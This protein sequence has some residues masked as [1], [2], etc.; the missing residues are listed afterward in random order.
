MTGGREIAE[1]LNLA[2]QN[3]AQPHRLRP[4]EVVG[5]REVDFDLWRRRCKPRGKHSNADSTSMP[6]DG[7]NVTSASIATRRR[8]IDQPLGMTSGTTV[9]SSPNSFRT[10][11][12]L[13]RR[14]GLT[15][16]KATADGDDGAAGPG[17][18]RSMDIVL[19]LR[20]N[21]VRPDR[22]RRHT[23]EARSD[24]RREPR[25][26]RP[27]RSAKRN[28]LSALPP[29][30]RRKTCHETMRK[31]GRGERVA[32]HRSDSGRRKADR[33]N[34]YATQPTPRVDPPNCR[35]RAGG[36][37][38]GRYSPGNADDREGRERAP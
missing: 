36:S 33:K 26:D 10:T 16:S 24:L 11:L 30:A 34:T 13:R 20:G 23:T 4:R 14:R 1:V 9:T 32:R 27:L 7:P 6:V 8:E 28:T 15:S 18:E 5:V 25:E 12:S 22:A 37:N 3:L 21:R 35:G 38:R 19:Q 2:N 17:N 31:D 29:A